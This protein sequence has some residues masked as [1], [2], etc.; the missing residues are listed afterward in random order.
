MHARA[1]KEDVERLNRAFGVV[2]DSS[3][4]E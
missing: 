2:R 1:R 3:P 4:I